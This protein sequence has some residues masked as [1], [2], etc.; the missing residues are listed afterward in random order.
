MYWV[1]SMCVTK[2]VWGS[3]V[4]IGVWVYKRRGRNLYLV[5]EVDVRRVRAA[6]TSRAMHGVDMVDMHSGRGM[7]G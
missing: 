7:G 1:P 6:E 5:D 4:H 3:A 2:H